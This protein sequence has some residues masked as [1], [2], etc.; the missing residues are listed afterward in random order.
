MNPT[1]IIAQ[2]WSDYQRERRIRVEPK[3]FE[4]LLR[5]FPSVLIAQADGFTDTSEVHRLDEIVAF[6]C[7]QEGISLDA[8]DWRAEM[9]YLAI[10]A[11]F[12]REKFIEALRALLSQQKVLYREQAEF[13]YAVAAASTGDIVRNL[14]LRLR[15]TD[16]LSEEPVQLISEK[17]RA[18]IDRLVHELGFAEEA[19]E[20]LS[21]LRQL[22]EKAHG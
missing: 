11:A 6:L 15:R 18:E 2:V 10:D 21:Y 7:K 19:P 17:E 20:T 9:R 5:V 22:L 16:L 4:I 8:I 13:L 1:D 3:V 14:L 12:W